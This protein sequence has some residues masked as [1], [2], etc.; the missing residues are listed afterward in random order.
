MK[1]SKLLRKHQFLLFIAIFFIMGSM[2][3]KGSLTL[4]Q[5]TIDSGKIDNNAVTDSLKKRLEDSSLD[6]KL[7][8]VKGVLDDPNKF[9]AYIGQVSALDENSL[10]L[11]RN[12]VEKKAVFHK[13]TTMLF[14]KKNIKAEEIE[15][16]WYAMA[17]GKVD[18]DQVLTAQR[19]VFSEESPLVQIER[20]VV[21]G[22]IVEIDDK[23]ITLKDGEEFKFNFEK[24]STLKISGVDKPELTNVNVEDKAVAILRK[25]EEEYTL[26]ALFVWPGTGSPESFKN[27]VNATESAQPDEAE[28][29][30]AEE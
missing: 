20:K 27:Q 29:N 10:N 21:F 22:K 30:Q 9:Y 8:K 13:E 14:E 23:K 3:L 16:G 7:E 1:K 2:V 26:K 19:I 28:E 15:T 17:M 4:A 24:S 12:E 18:K 5:Q 6:E 25:E 11:K